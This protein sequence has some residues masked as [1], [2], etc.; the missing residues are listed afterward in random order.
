MSSKEIR[1]IVILGSGNVATQLSVVL[2]R[3]GLE[4]LQ[5][6]SREIKH[7]K[8]LAKK[9][10]TGYTDDLKSLNA[11]ADLY[12]LCVSDDALFDVINNISIKNSMVVHTS[13][14]TSINIFESSFSD[15]GVFY[16]LQTFSKD[17]EIDFSNIPICIEADTNMNDM[18]LATLAKKISENVQLINSDQRKAL[19]VAAVFASN[20]TNYF[21]IIADEI[22][23]EK[24]LSLDLIKPLITEVALRIH[25]S[26]PKDVQTGPAKRG[27]DLIVKAHLDFLN[28]HPEYQKLYK[29]ISTQIK[30][31]FSSQ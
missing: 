9:L 29:L 15:Y 12:V 26:K 14:T 6:Y 27:D 1:Q 22:L 3:A 11:S 28:S 20:F 16:P 21:Y 18:K 19:H 25:D 13:G 23:A 7:A 2:K 4:I 24:E 30:E 31:K 5:V 17:K 8:T 10:G